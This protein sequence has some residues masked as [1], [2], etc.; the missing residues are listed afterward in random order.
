VGAL[1]RERFVSE[2][3]TLSYVLPLRW[4][5]GSE[6][7]GLTSYLGRLRLDCAQILVV[8]GS[9]S[10]VYAANASAWGAL[11][12]HI[13][14][15]PDM[16]CQMGKVAGVNTGLRHCRHEAVVIADDDVRYERESL[17]R[18]DA[19]LDEF[20]LV[21]PQNFF[22]PLPW[23]ARWDTART[24]LNRAI[25]ADYP[26]T[27]GV[28]RATFI[29]MGG[30]DGDVMF[31]N[32]ELIRTVEASGGRPVAPLD[33][34][35]RRLPPTTAHFL[36]QRTRQAYDDF[37]I[38]LRMAAWL[39]LAPLLTLALLCR[40]RKPVGIAAL[41][42]ILLAEHGRRRF[43]GR[44]VFPPEASLLAPLWILE[45]GVCGWLAVLQRLRF[46]GVRYG[47]GVIT[48]AAHSK[49]QLRRRE[50]LRHRD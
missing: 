41:G 42:A 35:V 1:A 21:R 36:G 45:R 23:H 18:V 2:P 13:P 5:D 43:G 44:A 25:G 32:L 27:L 49:A 17:E 28:R 12:T 40:G 34:Y 11:V 46:G 22:D 47:D 9:D 20:D 15:D 16:L 39:A 30:Y 26:G 48:T 3:L 8:D 29:A 4:R 50:A 37:A 31:E 14:P 6:R 7:D 38:P 24:L 10:E 19:L 33:L